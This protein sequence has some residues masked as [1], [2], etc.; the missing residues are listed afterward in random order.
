MTPI[1]A[2]KQVIKELS[3]LLIAEPVETPRLLLRP[4]RDSDLADLYE[5]LAQKEQQRLAGNSP[6]D[7]PD[8]ARMTLEY[9]LGAEHPQAY[10]AIVLKDEN[11]VIGNLTFN[12]YPFLEQDEILRTLRGVTLSYILNEKYW[13]RGLMTELLRAVYPILFEKAG[14]DYIQS[15][16]FVFNEASAALQRKLGM[17][18]WAEERFEMNGI[19]YE[20]REMILFRDGYECPKTAQIQGKPAKSCQN[21]Y[22]L[23]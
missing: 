4:F 1:D 18:L 20:T 12:P 14:L 10:F 6:C 2:A 5:Y 13:R 8:D 9:I 23:Q 21:M 15:G 22:V 11:K 19:P 17:R 7:S 16:Y 3:A